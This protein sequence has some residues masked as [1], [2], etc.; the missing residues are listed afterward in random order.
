MPTPPF[1]P[2][3]SSVAKPVIGML[4]LPP[5]PGSPRYGG[6]MP[7]LRDA[8]LRDADALAEGGVHGLMIEN[9]GDVPFYPGRV[10]AYVVAQMTA[11]AAEIRRRVVQ[12]PLGINVLRND[13]QSALAIAHAV[14]AAFIRVNVLC[15]GRLADQGILQAIAH[16]L[17]RE[18]AM[19]KAD[20]KILAD[21][22]VK[23]SAP[24]APR[25]LA[26]EIDDTLHRGLADGLVVSGAGTGK[27][28]DP[29][30]VVDAK[31]YAKDVPVFV[32]SGVTARTVP[33]YTNYADGFIVGTAFKK[34]GDPRNA[35]EVARVKE[36][37]EKL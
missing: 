20:V 15:G 35:V 3:W 29:D 37:I 2:V 33:H 19:L 16:D 28:T 14:G 25:P 6:D 21:V 24:L 18:R 1:L 22:D 17:L 26:D 30:K 32:G 23:H 9:F 34:D 11:L 8:L 12:L 7:K 10:P 31:G 27:T 13:G 5:L 36:L 4:H